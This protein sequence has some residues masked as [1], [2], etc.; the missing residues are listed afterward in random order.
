MHGGGLGRIIAWQAQ[1]HGFDS[2]TPNGAAFT[3]A[4]LS[5]NRK[6]FAGDVAPI[7]LF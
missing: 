4:L 3:E 6:G 7:V 2:G 1:L 5:M